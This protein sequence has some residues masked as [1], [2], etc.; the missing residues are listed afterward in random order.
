M[1]WVFFAVL[2]AVIWAMVNMIDKY[3]LEKLID[4]PIVPLMATGIIGVIMAVLIYSFRGF[5]ELSS[6]NI[7]LAF[8]AGIM[9]IFSILLYFK[10]VKIEEISRV[11]TL[12][13]L[14]PLFIAVFAAMFLGEILTPVKY[15]GIVLLV[16]GAILISLKRPFRISFGKA[17]YMMVGA[18]IFLAVYSILMKHLLN[19]ADFWTVFSYIRV[20]GLIPVAPIIY[21]N[22][23]HV[24]HAVEKSGKKVI[25][26]LTLAETMNLFAVF[27]IT[28]ATAIGFVSLVNALTSVQPFFT[29]LFAVLISAF[30]PKIFKEEIGKKTVMLKLAAIVMMFIGVLLVV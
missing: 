29:L 23:K 2:A 7:G 30:L 27:A 16:L 8:I 13:Y 17:F 28:I 12:Y 11:I 21:F 24:V 25:V 14:A 5:S 6:Y 20:G 15:L 18:S 26:Y 19:Y 9:Y 4:K 1:L 22:F 10:A 3:V